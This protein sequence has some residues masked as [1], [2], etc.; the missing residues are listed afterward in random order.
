MAFHKTEGTDMIS[1]TRFD[2]PLGRMLAT[3]EAGALTGLYF[4][5]QRHFPDATGDWRDDPQ[6]EPFAALRAQLDEYFA[7]TRAVFDVAL[8]PVGGRGTPFQRAVWDAIAAVPLGQTTTYSSLA[9]TCKRPSAAR[10]SGAATGRN[11]ISVIIPCHRIL[12]SDGAFTG[13][14]GGLDRKRTLLAF[15]AAVAAGEARHI[16][17][18][19]A[20]ANAAPALAT[21][22]PRQPELTLS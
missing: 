5:G 15:E 11:P 22:R 18:F 17:S 21:A 16:S 4:I 1:T 10:A 6:A 13:Y 2:S 19:V 14:A 20:A 7:G 8:N 12:G 9:L 3:A